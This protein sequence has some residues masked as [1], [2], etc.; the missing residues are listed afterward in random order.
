MI[1]E[2]YLN[3]THN[4]NTGIKYILATSS[5]CF[6]KSCVSDGPRE[7][8]TSGNAENVFTRILISVGAMERG[9]A[10]EMHPRG[11]WSPITLAL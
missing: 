4:R 5:S 11:N 3:V 8:S 1:S 9:S 2:Y 7:F 6:V 10:K